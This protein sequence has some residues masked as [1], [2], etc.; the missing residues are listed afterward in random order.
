M[1]R[2]RSEAVEDAWYDEVKRDLYVA[3]RSGRTYAYLDVPDTLYDD[4]AQHEWTGL[5]QG[6]F[7][8]WVIK[9]N[10]R[11]REVTGRPGKAA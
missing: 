2:R 11:Y 4:L 7:V 5:S 6:K 8:N 9:P 1:P 3:F 10:F